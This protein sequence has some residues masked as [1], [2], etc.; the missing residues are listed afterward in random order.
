[1][2]EMEDILDISCVGSFCIQ[3]D[4][5]SSETSKCLIFFTISWCNQK[6]I[7]FLAEIKLIN[8]GDKPIYKQTF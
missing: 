6:S 5:D 2:T 3:K 4:K 8:S 1:M 7:K